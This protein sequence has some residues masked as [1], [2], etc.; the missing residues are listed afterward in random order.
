MNSMNN[1]QRSFKK[2]NDE[3]KEEIIIHTW[4]KPYPEM[5]VKKENN[6]NCEINE[7]ND[8]NKIKMQQIKENLTCFMLKSNYIDNP[9]I[10]LGYPII[11]C[12]AQ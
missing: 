2:I 7:K 9:D 5:F 6:N 10:L 1:Y 4:N 3:G 8:E 12:K 11:Q